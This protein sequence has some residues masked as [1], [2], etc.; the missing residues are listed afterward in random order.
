MVF[1]A[2]VEQQARSSPVIW[3][4]YY[5]CHTHLF[6]DYFLSQFLTHTEENLTKADF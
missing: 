2:L 4:E 3:R 6:L 1:R 5:G